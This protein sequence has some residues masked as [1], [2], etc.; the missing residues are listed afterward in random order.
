MKISRNNGITATE[1]ILSAAA[2]RSFLRLWS[3]SS[4]QNDRTKSSKGIGQEIADLLMIFGNDVVIFSDKESS[5]Q[6]HKPIKL[7]WERWYRRTIENSVTQ[8]VGADRWLREHPDRVFIDR[9]CKEPLPIDLPSLDKRTTH[10]VAISNGANSASRN[11]FSHPRG[12]F[13]IYP[14]LK[15]SDHTS[16]KEKNW[17]PFMIGDVNSRGKFI[18][19]FDSS[20]LSILMQEL[21]TPRDFIDYLKARKNFIR[22]GKLAVATGEED[23]LA[24]YLMNGFSYNRKEFIPSK[25]SKRYR[26][27][28]ASIPEGQYETYIR[29]AHYYSYSLAKDK[30]RFWDSVIEGVTDHILDGTSIK[31]LG[32]EPSSKLAEKALRSMASE[33]RESR[34]LLSDVLASALNKSILEGYSRFV[35]RVLPMQFKSTR[36]VGYVFINLPHDKN[37]GSLDDYREYKAAMLHAYCLSF[38]EEQ[39]NLNGVVGISFDARHVNGQLRSKSEDVMFLDAPNWDERIISEIYSSRDIFSMSHP[40]ELSSHEIKQIKGKR[41]FSL[42][43]TR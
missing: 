8:L 24:T 29:S 16:Q 7:A 37:L 32:I 36:K 25:F 20:S 28:L 31:V 26:R 11:Y 33:T 39:R 5:W 19:V 43:L 27:K 17:H 34:I 40:N 42:K 4:P 13:I 23:L 38:L 1:K 2:D 18:H 3:Y 21:D 6:T 10:L 12:T 35:R 14:Y 30:S 41:P 9:F 22:S 15:D